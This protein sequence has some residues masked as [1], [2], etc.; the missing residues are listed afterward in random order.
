M[1]RA[2]G[3]KLQQLNEAELRA[4][5]AELWEAAESVL[6]CS[7]WTKDSSGKSAIALLPGVF[8]K[9]RVAVGYPP[10]EHEHR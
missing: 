1:R 8:D 6:I 4:K 7:Y 3:D 2:T 5:L 10:I 9:L